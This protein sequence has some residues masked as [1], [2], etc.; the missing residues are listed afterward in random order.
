M[1][2][3]GGRWRGR[4]LAIAPG[5]DVRPTPDRARETL[6]NWLMPVIEGARCLDLFAGTGALGLEALSRGASEAWFVERDPALAGALGA[7]ARE[8]GVNDDNARVLEMPVERFLGSV[9]ATRFD[10]VFL[11]PPY[12][13]DLAPTLG[14]LEP[15]LEA[16]ALV[17]VERAASGDS[18]EKIVARALGERVTLVKKSRAGAVVYGLLRRSRRR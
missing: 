3:I 16:E 1:R 15:W 17:Y 2:I 10:I 6:F 7:R 9:P 18:L 4:K 8:L 5:A 13:L 11:D 12:A 14:V